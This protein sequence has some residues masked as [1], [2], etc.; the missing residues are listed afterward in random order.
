[1]FKNAD[2]RWTSVENSQFAEN[3]EINQKMAPRSH[4]LID[5]SVLIKIEKESIFAPKGRRK[6]RKN[7][8]GAK[9]RCLPAARKNKD[10]WF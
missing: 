9:L 7:I 2:P 4:L 10:L 5:F 8:N 6:N 3:R 1:M